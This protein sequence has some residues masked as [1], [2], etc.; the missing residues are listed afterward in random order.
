MVYS[1][2]ES[3]SGPMTMDMLANIPPEL[4][5]PQHRTPLSAVPTGAARPTAL[6]CASGC[7]YPV[8]EGI[9]RFTP[10]EAYTG[11]FGRQW[12]KFAKTQLDSYTGV[13]LSRTRLARCMGGTLEPVA[14]KS[15]FEAGSGAGRF[16]EVL[17]E[18]GARVVACDLSRAVEASYAN[19]GGRERYFVCQAD[20]RTPPVLPG[21][22]DVVVCLGVIQHTPS[23][24]ATIAAL[25]TYLKPGGLLVIDHYPP[26]YPYTKPR[27]VLRELML[28]LPER[29]ASRATMAISHALM[30]TH[31]LFWSQSRVAVRARG[32]LSRYSPLVDYYTDYPQLPRHILKQWCVLDTHDTITDFYKHLRSPEQIR[33]IL[34][35]CGLEVIAV[36]RGGNG[37][38]ARAR[39][40]LAAAAAAGA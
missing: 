5:C 34:S 4:C 11:A 10:S 30:R 16:T 2:K 18:A 22:F 27:Q 36:E 9:P 29:L 21:S 19:F 12:R 28:K 8:V 23:P 25:A 7:R 6:D 26:D 24:E 38:E 35:E 33:Q 13:P 20:I 17:L 39:R 15:V 1:L 14:G 3:Y 31:S 40:P 32:W 37:V